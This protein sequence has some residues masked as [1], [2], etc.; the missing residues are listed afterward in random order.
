VAG[1]VFVNEE[2]LG[3]F[4]LPC[5]QSDQLVRIPGSISF[6]S[7]DKTIMLTKRW[8]PS[9]LGGQACTPRWV[10]WTRQ[11]KASLS[12]SKCLASWSTLLG[13]G[14]LTLD[15]EDVLEQRNRMQ[16]GV[17]SMGDVERISGE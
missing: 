16:R 14:M 12:R 9:F 15:V 11:G 3:L 5:K 6:K 4:I 8:A 13:D 17:L 10:C 7:I 2:R 1:E